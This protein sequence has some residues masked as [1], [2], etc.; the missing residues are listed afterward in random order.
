MRHAV[1]GATFTSWR[2]VTTSVGKRN[3]GSIGPRSRF[4]TSALIAS[5]TRRLNLNAGDRAR[6][7]SRFAVETNSQPRYC[8]SPRMNAALSP[9]AS[10]KSSRPCFSS[11][12]GKKFLNMNSVSDHR[13]AAESTISRCSIASGWRAA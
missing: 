10:R 7:S 4:A 3:S 11:W 6:N 2:P 12:S 8:C 5:F 13:G 9:T 1:L